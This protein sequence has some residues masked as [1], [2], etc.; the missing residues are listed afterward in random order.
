MASRVEDVEVMVTTLG[1]SFRFEVA[2]PG[3]TEVERFGARPRIRIEVHRVSYQVHQEYYDKLFVRVGG[4]VRRDSYGYELRR[5]FSIDEF[6]DETHSILK[7]LLG[8]EGWY[9][10]PW[11][12]ID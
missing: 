10:R 6:G 3:K 2:L 9:T 7:R 1:T 5:H 4:E 11:V 12:L 8:E